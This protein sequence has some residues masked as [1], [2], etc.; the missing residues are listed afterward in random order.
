MLPV[1]S[2]GETAACVDVRAASLDEASPRSVVCN[3]P[4][5]LGERKR[6]SRKAGSG[7]D[8]A[9]DAAGVP[10]YLTPNQYSKA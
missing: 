6:E 2:F 10:V 5:W 1:V 4:C 9:A 8:D 7:Q 3:P